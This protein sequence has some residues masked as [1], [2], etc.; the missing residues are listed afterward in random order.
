MVIRPTG[1]SGASL[2]GTRRKAMKQQ[3]IRSAIQ[4]DRVGQDWTPIAGQHWAPIDNFAL[5][6]DRNRYELSNVRCVPKSALGS[7]VWRSWPLRRAATVSVDQAM[8][9]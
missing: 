8:A 1:A 5:T 4:L 9:T 2:V 3:A 7:M 6:G